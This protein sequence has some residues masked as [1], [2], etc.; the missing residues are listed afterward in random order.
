MTQFPSSWW[1]NRPLVF[2]HRGASLLAPE[3]TMAAF[4]KAIQIG[5]D[6]VELDVRLSLDG[7]PVVLHNS[8]VDKT[9][10]GHGSV[11]D[12]TLDELHLLD[13]GS[14]FDNS[15]QNQVIPTLEEV[16]D[17]FGQTT[18]INIELKARYRKDPYLAES[19]CT[20]ISKMGLADRV[21]FSC[22][23]PYLLRQTRKLLPS[24]PNG[25]LYTIH[26]PIKRMKIANMPVEAVHPYF[27]AISKEY[28]SRMHNLNKRV[29][30]WTVDDLEVAQKCIAAK[31]DVIITNDPGSILHMLD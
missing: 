18:L 24:I 11:Y 16:L 29:V 27:G 26:S 22:F 19:V 25:Y 7:I 13:A 6:G 5:A 14:W 23:N 3:N 9:T 21:W 8:H 31:V 17:E 1:I 30:V 4:H 15:Y 20:L 12:L 28:V 2:A 10:N